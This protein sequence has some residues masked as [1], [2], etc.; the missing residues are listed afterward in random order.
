MSKLKLYVSLEDRAEIY[1]IAMICDEWNILP[2]FT[3]DDYMILLMACHANHKLNLAKLK[4]ASH[5]VMVK[6]IE[7]FNQSINVDTLKLEA[8]WSAYVINKRDMMAVRA[9]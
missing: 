6:E 4:L 5:D 8:C 7:N 1:E 9:K 3:G 2:G